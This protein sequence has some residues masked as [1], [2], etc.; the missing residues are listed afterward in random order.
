MPK[1]S[2][3]Y[4]HDTV[5]ITKTNFV[6]P[7]RSSD[8]TTIIPVHTGK[9][10]ASYSDAGCGSSPGSGTHHTK[11]SGIGVLASEETSTSTSTSTMTTTTTTT[12]MK[13]A[14]IETYSSSSP[15][16]SSG[17]VRYCPFEGRQ[18]IYTLCAPGGSEKQTTVGGSGSSADDV[19]REGTFSS[20]AATV[21]PRARNPLARLTAAASPLWTSVLSALGGG[22]DA[23]QYTRG[24]TG[25]RRRGRGLVTEAEVAERGRARLAKFAGR[26]AG[27]SDQRKANDAESRAKLADLRNTRN[28][29]TADAEKASK[30]DIIADLKRSLGTARDLVRAQQQLLDQQ[31][32]M[33]ARNRE[34]LA[35]ATQLPRELQD[36]S[37][38]GDPARHNGNGTRSA[39]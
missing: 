3:R 35:R 28:D 10:A 30:R 8:H 27:L 37:G 32:A 18:D 23:H 25:P 24:G 9:T 17:G 2:A 36:A 26:R 7:S 15:S 31:F 14:S 33:V 22:G 29:K 13:T 1:L 39:A 34:S 38:G 20:S 6:L 16:S 12:K 5:T 11:S 19:P 21:G 4:N